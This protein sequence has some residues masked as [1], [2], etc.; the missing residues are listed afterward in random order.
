MHKLLALFLVLATPICA[1]EPDSD[2]DGLS[3]F[4]EIH[5][6][7][8]DPKNADSDG[9]GIPDGDWLE[10]REYQYTVRSV[11]LVMRP[12]TPEFINDDYQDAR[13]LAESK[14]HVKLEV[15][16]YPFN[17]LAN[18]I[19]GDPN[20]RSNKSLRLESRR[21][22]LKPGL[23]SDWTPELRQQIL[24]ALTADGV[25]LKNS[26]D[27]D[28]CQ[29]AANLLLKRAKYETGFTTFL[30]AFDEQGKPYVP[31]NLEAYARS[32]MSK[33]SLSFAQQFEREMSAKGMFKNRSRGSCTSSAIYLNGCL[34][35][36]GIPTRIIYCIPT[37]D[38][39]DVSELELV[40]NGITHKKLRARLLRAFEKK[41]G[42]TSHT[43]NEVYIGGRWRRLNYNKLGQGSLDAT[44]GLMTHLATFDDWAEAKAWKTIGT[45]QM[46][47]NKGDV[48]GFK[49]PYSC[50]YLSDQFGKHSGVTNPEA[51]PHTATI[52]ALYSHDSKSLPADVRANLISRRRFGLIAGSD[53]FREFLVIQPFS[54]PQHRNPVPRQGHCQ[55]Q[56]R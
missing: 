7:L 41:T 2:G 30:T 14:E 56:V 1:Q 33:A 10:R 44:L 53:Q 15:I 54:R 22:W 21:R 8:T 35:A 34:R 25:D 46:A 39:S 6:Y 13:I 29:K 36:I 26:N 47:S 50:L 27:L 11:V 31:K 40:R 3:D 38:A 42:W 28:L 52:H 49:N 51:D 55:A 48:F 20:W 23:S 12:V 4:L 37:I 19:K 5:K 32:R 24:A 43:F 18:T 17:T 16:Y 9:D 45:R